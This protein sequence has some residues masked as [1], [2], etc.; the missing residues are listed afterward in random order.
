MVIGVLIAWIFYRMYFPSVFDTKNGGK[1]YPPRRFGIP[2]FGGGTSF[3]PF[4]QEMVLYSQQPS[5]GLSMSIGGSTTLRSSYAPPPPPPAAPPP[6]IQYPPVAMAPNIVV[7]IKKHP[8]HYH[9]TTNHSPNHHADAHQHHQSHHHGHSE[10]Q[11]VAP[12]GV[13]FIPVVPLN[14]RPHIHTHFNPPHQH[15]HQRTQSHQQSQKQQRSSS[16]TNN[17]SNKNDSNDSCL[18]SSFP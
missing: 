18:L 1:A 4:A 7:N 9:H 3:Y 5:T 13:P 11:S 14:A 15:S 10:F 6:V 16:N 8:N 2:Y 12:M 17:N